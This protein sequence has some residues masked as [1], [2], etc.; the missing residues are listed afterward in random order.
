MP[1]TSA[2]SLSRVLVAGFSDAST[3][4]DVSPIELSSDVALVAVSLLTVNVLL[5]LLMA[6]K[7]NPV[8]RW[9]H[10]RVKTFQLHN[11]TGY[12]ALAIAT[13][14]PLLLLFSDDP[15]FR[16]VDLAWPIHSPKQP[17]INTLGAIAFWGIAFVVTTSYFRNQLGRKPWKALH[18]TSYGAAV[19]FL[20]HGILAD[21]TLKNAPLDPLDAEKVYVELLALLVV[22]TTV[23]RLRWQMQQ[24]PARVHRPKPTREERAALRRRLVA[25]T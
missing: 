6:T 18:F 25:E 24:P 19:F 7:Y 15:K 9:P 8:R 20:I 5:G 10:R 21:P 22:A 23:V 14:H 16:L 2:A 4:R 3:P 13:L 17:S 11:W 1:R 12:T